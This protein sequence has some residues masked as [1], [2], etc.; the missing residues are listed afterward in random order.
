MP[1]DN[2]RPRYPSL[3]VNFFRHL[4]LAKLL[5]NAT[6]TVI[7][8]KTYEIWVFL[9][10][11]FFHKNDFFPKSFRASNF[12]LYWYKIILFRKR[13]FHLNRFFCKNLSFLIW[14]NKKLCWKIVSERNDFNL[15]KSI[16]VKVGVRKVCRWQ[17]AVWLVSSFH[18]QLYI[19]LQMFECINSFQNLLA[20]YNAFE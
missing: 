20:F 8:P 14:R 18:C 17:R 9:R 3:N 11:V 16:F 5:Q 10:N 1:I 7:V 15:L 2:I 19:F 13:L 6:Q 12:W 4:F